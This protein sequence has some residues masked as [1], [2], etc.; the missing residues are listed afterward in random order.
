MGWRGE[1][2]ICLPYSN[3]KA[4]S[5]MRGEDGEDIG[6]EGV[7]RYRRGWKLGLHCVIGRRDE[8][9]ID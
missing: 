3:A 5:G 6:A 1:R 2:G 7:W 4:N 9:N 8:E